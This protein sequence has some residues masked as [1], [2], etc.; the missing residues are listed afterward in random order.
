MSIRV[1]ISRKTKTVVCAGLLTGA[2]SLGTVAV[3]EVTTAYGTPA[4]GSATITTLNRATLAANTIVNAE[5]V[6]LHTHG[7]I[8]VFQTS[9]VAQ[10]GW[11]SGWHSHTGPVILNVKS[12]SVRLNAFN[13]DDGTCAA[14]D[15]AGGSVFV[16]RP[17]F[18]YLAQNVGSVDVTLFTTQLIPQGAAT[19]VDEP[20]ACGL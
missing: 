19:R 15:V 14:T 6:Q 1:R 18:R 11:A 12:G 8:D 2:A 10:P 5:V 13:P 16:E 4:T 3:L 9:T 7:P 20:A 17:G